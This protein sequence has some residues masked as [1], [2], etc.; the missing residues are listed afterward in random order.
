VA[1]SEPPVFICAPT[2]PTE[3]LWETKK[4]DR[5]GRYLRIVGQYFGFIL[6]TLNLEV[7]CLEAF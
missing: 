2:I 7:I 1:S 3:A 5:S 4:A 6:I